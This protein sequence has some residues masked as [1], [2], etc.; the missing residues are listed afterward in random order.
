[1]SQLPRMS[2]I[3]VGV[4]G[5]LIIGT[6]TFAQTPAPAPAP[7]APAAAPASGLPPTATITTPGY[8]AAGPG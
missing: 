4:C 1:M 7:A 8:P 3:A 5:T 2:R 6:A